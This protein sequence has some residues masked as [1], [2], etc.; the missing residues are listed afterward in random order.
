MSLQVYAVNTVT[1]I[2]V[3]WKMLLLN[4]CKGNFF[5]KVLQQ[6]YQPI[7][8]LLDLYCCSGQLEI[9]LLLSGCAILLLLYKLCRVT[10]LVKGANLRHGPKFVMA[11][12][13]CYPK[14]SKSLIPS[15]QGF[16]PCSLL[17]SPFSCQELNTLGKHLQPFM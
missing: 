2:T 16:V 13:A 11:T 12:L 15:T 9:K 3:K 14:I 17:A 6:T 10:L 8:Q 1:S 7:D 4:R 5:D